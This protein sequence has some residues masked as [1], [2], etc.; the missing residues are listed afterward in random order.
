MENL[1]YLQ[2]YLLG[3]LGTQPLFFHFYFRFIGKILQNIF[4]VGIGDLHL[5]IHWFFLI[6]LHGWV[7]S[8]LC[9]K[10]I[11]ILGLLP[12]WGAPH[13][14]FW[15]TQIEPFP[16]H[17]LV[18]LCRSCVPQMVKWRSWHFWD[19]AWHIVWGWDRSVFVPSKWFQFFVS[20]PFRAVHW[21]HLW[22]TNGAPFKQ[23]LQ[24]TAW[25]IV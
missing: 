11:L 19:C 12:P 23:T 1:G 24:N 8:I 6:S 13:G 22:G 17:H 25:H 2:F 4:A 15:S 18:E 9:L 20:N 7:P 5:C 16:P 21:K 3:P 10:I 14:D